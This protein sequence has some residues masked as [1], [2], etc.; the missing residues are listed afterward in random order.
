[1]EEEKTEEIDNYNNNITENNDDITID[2]SGDIVEEKVKELYNTSTKKEKKPDPMREVLPCPNCN[3]RM[4]KH[5]LD[6]KHFKVCKGKKEEDVK[7]EAQ[8]NPGEKTVPDIEEL[9]PQPI[10][11]PKAKTKPK[12]KPN[13][14]PPPP[15]LKRAITQQTPQSMPYQNGFPSIPTDPY[16]ALPFESPLRNSMLKALKTKR[17]MNAPMLR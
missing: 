4:S 5:T 12:A 17:M 9:P 10:P 14:M 13:N 11:K 1:M 15:I 8:T 16:D 2:N 7:K 6:Y 3:K